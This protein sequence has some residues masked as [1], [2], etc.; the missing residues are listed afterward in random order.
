[1]VTAVARLR[2]DRLVLDAEVERPLSAEILRRPA[3]E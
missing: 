2:S 3:P 1:M